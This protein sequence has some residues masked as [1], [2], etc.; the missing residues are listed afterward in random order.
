MEPRVHGF[1]LTLFNSQQHESN[2]SHVTRL[3]FSPSQ[4]NQ[5]VQGRE[6]G[7]LDRC[8]GQDPSWLVNFMELLCSLVQNCEEV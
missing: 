4:A 7:E 2:F 8:Q 3:R 6:L 5:Q 1:Y